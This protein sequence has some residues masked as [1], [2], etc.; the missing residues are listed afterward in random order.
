MRAIFSKFLL[1]HS[2]LVSAFL[3]SCE[4]SKTVRSTVEP[5][6]TAAATKSADKKPD[7]DAGNKTTTNAPVTNAPVTN[8]P[9]TNAPV[10]NTPKVTNGSVSNTIETPKNATTVEQNIGLMKFK[11][12]C[13]QKIPNGCMR[14][15]REEFITGDFKSSYSSYVAGCA[16]DFQKKD[17]C[18]AKGSYK[19][20]A[21]GCYM[22]AQ[23]AIKQLKLKQEP[24]LLLDCACLKEYT[25]ACKEIASLNAK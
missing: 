20:D 23:V 17:S 15:A 9:V 8:A 1:A 24:K 21:Y 19:G 4:E 5:A 6:P 10:T 11:L 3:W 2:F 18:S 12:E 25:P 13:D 14:L 22:A 7:A 16:L